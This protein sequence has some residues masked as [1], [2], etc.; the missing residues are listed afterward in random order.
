MFYNCRSLVTLTMNK[1]DPIKIK[2]EQMSYLFY[3]CTRIVNLNIFLSINFTNEK[4]IDMK[5]IFQNCESLVTLNL[6]LF[7]TPNEEII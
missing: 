1:F 6:A 3:N 7:Y 4:I 5:G 2:I